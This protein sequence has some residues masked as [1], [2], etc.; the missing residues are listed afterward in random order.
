MSLKKQ[1]EDYLKS[2]VD[3]NEDILFFD[4]MPNTNLEN[5]EI[6]NYNKQPINIHSV[7]NNLNSNIEKIKEKNNNIQI[8]QQYIDDKKNEL[9]KRI[10]RSSIEVKQA[11]SLDE[12][13]K[14]IANCNSC[15]LSNT[16]TNLVFGKGNPNAK[17]MIIGEAPGTDEDLQGEPFVGR[18]GQLLTKILLA[19]KLTR[20]EVYIANICKCRPP[21]N[22]R[23]TIEEVFACECYLQKQIELISPK[24]ILALGL[25]AA[26]TLFKK[27]NKMSEVR[28]KFFDY[29]G[30][31]TMITYH[32]A[33]LLRN[34]T[35]KKF[36]WDDVQL[37]RK[38]YDEEN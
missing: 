5:L 29:N 33:A 8:K 17:L 30:I 2:I 10:Y 19:I 24:F 13:N 26:D 14:L 22:R 20:D 34:P 27:T 35:W 3:S 16:R 25:T 37:L 32:P 38:Y 7:D 1:I 4:E 23:P 36:V 11:K 18:A 12:L 21:L 6:E 28:G 15:S 31:R 9:E